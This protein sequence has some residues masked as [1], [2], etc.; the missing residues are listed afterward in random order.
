MVKKFGLI[1]IQRKRLNR[2]IPLIRKILN[3]S[4]DGSYELTVVVEDNAGNQSEIEKTI[5]IDKEAPQLDGEPAITLSTVND[6][7]IGK[8]INF[9]TF[10]TFFNEK[11]KLKFIQKITKMDR[12]LK[13]FN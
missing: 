1:T 11:I 9:L 12:V 10:G 13:K 5:Y 6:G 4:N 3:V 2:F 8:A 7:V